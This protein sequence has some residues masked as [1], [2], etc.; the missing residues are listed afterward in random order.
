MPKRDTAKG[1]R[2][3]IIIDQLNKKTPYGGV[4]VRELA[5]RFEVTERTIYRD[6]KVIEN[7]LVIPLVRQE[8]GQGFTDKIEIRLPAQS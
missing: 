3:N 1:L 8:D 7:D 2:I 4:T 5:E 6:L